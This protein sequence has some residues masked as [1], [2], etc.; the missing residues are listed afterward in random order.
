MKIFLT[1]SA[2]ARAE[3]RNAQN[4]AEGRGDDYAGVLADI[5][6]RDN[7]D[8]T[9]KVSPLV[10]ADDAVIVDTSDLGIDG[11]ID[12]LYEVVTERTGVT[13]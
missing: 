7:L 4:I 11:V 5:E 10:A 1:A 3:R 9:R 2:A 8:S 13:P 12:R 6:R